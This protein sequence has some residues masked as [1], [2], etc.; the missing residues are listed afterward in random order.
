MQPSLKKLRVFLLWDRDPS[1]YTHHLNHK[2]WILL[3]PVS[4]GILSLILARAL[5]TPKRENQCPIKQRRHEIGLLAALRRETDWGRSFCR[6]L[7]S[8]QHQQIREQFHTVSRAVATCSLPAYNFQE[9]HLKALP[10]YS[11]QETEKSLLVL[12]LRTDPS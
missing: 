3:P 6:A 8:S 5:S 11:K 7:L 10:D 4:I 2:S 9:M 12:A 1:L